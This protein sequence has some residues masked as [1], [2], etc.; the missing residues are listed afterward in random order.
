MSDDLERLG[1]LMLDEFKRVHERF[2]GVDERINGLDGRL[3]RVE[4]RLDTIGDRLSNI[5]A[6]LKDIHRRLDALEEAAMNFSGFAKEI[7][8]LLTRVTAIEKH[9][10][11]HKK[12]A[13]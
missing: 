6:E 3:G 13:A 11:L 9:L 1:R 12:L 8:H 7:D 10:G 2:D 4:A 5:E